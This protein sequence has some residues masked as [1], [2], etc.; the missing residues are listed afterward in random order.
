MRKNKRGAMELSVGAIVILLLAITFLSLGLVFIKGI[1]G[2]MFSKFDEQISQEPEPPKPSSSHI[3]TFSRNPIKSKEENVETIKISILNPSQ[4]DWLNRQFI[5]TEGLCGKA[6]GICF[7]DVKDTTGTCDTKDNA[8]DNDPDCDYLIFPKC[9]PEEKDEKSC[10]ISN[11]ND[12]TPSKGDLYCPMT[13]GTLPD[14]D[15]KPKEGIDVYLK[16]DKRIMEKPFK[17]NTGSI[18][19]GDFKTNVLLL[20][21][22]SK[23]PEGQYLCQLRAFAEDKEYMEDLVVRIENE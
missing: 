3:I 15:C 4:E 18:K 2:K 9:D 5:K 16:C 17:R 20:R 7:I 13:P 6:D 14:A 21:L 12:G 19:A 1:L 11:I 10:L 22:K 8:K 23:I